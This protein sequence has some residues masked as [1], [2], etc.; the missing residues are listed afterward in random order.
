MIFFQL[1]FSILNYFK[2]I[3]VQR[4]VSDKL[5]GT[6]NNQR[7]NIE[8]R[9]IFFTNDFFVANLISQVFVIYEVHACFFIGLLVSNKLNINK[10][11]SIIRRN[12]RATV[13]KNHRRNFRT[14]KKTKSGTFRNPSKFSEYLFFCGVLLALLDSL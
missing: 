7:R 13:L 4:L 2:I 10:Y 11:M 8:L 5:F 14:S 6:I 12:L 3:K 1:R 9:I